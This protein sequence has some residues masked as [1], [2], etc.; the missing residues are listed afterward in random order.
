MN[1]LG[2]KEYAE[3][4]Y[5]LRVTG[6]EEEVLRFKKQFETKHVRL[7]KTY[8]EPEEKDKVVEDA[9]NHLVSI[10][11]DRD[12]IDTL[13]QN[14]NTN[15]GKEVDIDISYEASG[16]SYGNF[17]PNL[18]VHPLDYM[19]G[20][21]IACD[22]PLETAVSTIRKRTYFDKSK[23]VSEDT[24]LTYVYE[25]FEEGCFTDHWNVVFEMSRQYPELEFWLE[26][27]DPKTRTNHF[28]ACK[29]TH[30]RTDGVIADIVD[31]KRTVREY[32]LTIFVEECPYCNELI[33]LN[34]VNN[35]YIENVEGQ[36]AFN[37][38]GTFIHTGMG[39]NCCGNKV[40]IVHEEDYIY[41]E[42][43][44]SLS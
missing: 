38:I 11:I 17:N 5:I 33:F 3:G 30:M 9:V 21:G 42:K 43:D 6:F 36:D 37:E 34:D 14:S 24:V 19:Y 1:L 44:S 22:I 40:A 18:K 4:S 25:V 2:L 8:C 35:N 26:M 29:D 7:F 28:R 13:I 39:P 15:P 27:I 23:E 32:N 12:T 31:F 20:N 10:G 16:P 41:L